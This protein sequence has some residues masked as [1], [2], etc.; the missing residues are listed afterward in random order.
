MKFK[1]TEYL[2]VLLNNNR[3]PQYRVMSWDMTDVDGYG[4]CISKVEIE[5]EFA[6]PADFD[7]ITT[8][9]EMLKKKQ[10]KLRAEF[11]KALEENQARINSLLA[12]EHA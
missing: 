3:Q 4:K 1:H 9:V 2:H 10:D 11:Q 5:L 7:P 12:I 6:L 8:E